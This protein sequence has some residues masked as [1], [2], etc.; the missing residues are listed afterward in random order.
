V[1]TESDAG[2]RVD[3]EVG[4]EWCWRRGRCGWCVFEYK[5]VDVMKASP[6]AWEQRWDK[7]GRFSEGNVL[8]IVYSTLGGSAR[9]PDL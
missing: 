5:E 9:T 3:Q 7:L 1:G 6:G 2:G 4:V 8:C